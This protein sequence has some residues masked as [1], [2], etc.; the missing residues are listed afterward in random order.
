MARDPRRLYRSLGLGGGLQRQL[1]VN[2]G[3]IDPLLPGQLSGSS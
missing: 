3:L 1:D 2:G